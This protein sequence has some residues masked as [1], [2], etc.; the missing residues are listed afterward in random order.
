MQRIIE[1]VIEENL[2][3]REYNPEEAQKQAEH[4]V[5]S[6]R[7]GVKQLNVP[8]YK[9]IV[10]SVIGQVDGQGVRIASKCLWDEMNDN[11][12][13]WTYKNHS[14]FCTGIVFGIYYE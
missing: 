4:I 5:N 7:S 3:D 12:A 1:Q 10:Q 8:C 14:L 13:S 2:K 6:I 11:Y 9:I